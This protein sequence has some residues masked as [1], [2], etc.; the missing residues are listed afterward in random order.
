MA[1]FIR[2]KISVSVII[3][4]EDSILGGLNLITLETL[5]T[6]FLALP[7]TYKVEISI[8]LFNSFFFFLLSTYKGACPKEKYSRVLV[9]GLYARFSRESLSGNSPAYRLD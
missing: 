5:I 9:L 4:S 3:Y 1:F 8:S 6:F 2:F 7:L